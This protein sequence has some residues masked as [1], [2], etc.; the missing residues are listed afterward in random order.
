MVQKI[1]TVY[2]QLP[3]ANRRKCVTYTCTN[4]EAGAVNLFGKTYGLPGTVCNHLSYQIWG[5]GKYNAEVV[6]A[7]GHR[8]NPGI[9]SLFFKE[10]TKANVIIGNKYSIA[11]E[12]NLSVYI[13]RK[14]LLSLKNAWERLENYSF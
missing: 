10:V 7:F 8:F 13:C 12:Q 11:P 4:F 1:A 2:H 14:P 3:E 6:I 9:L 5:F